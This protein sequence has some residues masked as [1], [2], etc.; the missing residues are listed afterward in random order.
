MVAQVALFKQTNQDWICWVINKT[1]LHSDISRKYI[2]LYQFFGEA[3]KGPAQGMKSKEI[4]GCSSRRNLKRP[5]IQYYKTNYFLNHLFDRVVD[6]GN[7]STKLST[8]VD[9]E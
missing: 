4:N 2:S 1:Y 5:E 3:T 6:E 9:V 7:D 8:E